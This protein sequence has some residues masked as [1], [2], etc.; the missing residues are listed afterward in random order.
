LVYKSAK[1]RDRAITKKS[2]KALKIEQQLKKLCLFGSNFRGNASN[3]I[4][5]QY[6]K[7]KVADYKKGV[8]TGK[9]N[10]SHQTYLIGNTKLG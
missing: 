1:D 7:G 4:N 2:G 8:D 3:T 10:N 6:I 5:F 9:G